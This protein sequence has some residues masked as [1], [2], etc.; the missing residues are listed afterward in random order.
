MRGDTGADAPTSK[1]AG[2]SFAGGPPAYSLPSALVRLMLRNPILPILIVALPSFAL[3]VPFY[4]TL[5]NFANLLLASS[6]LLLLASGGALVMIT[7]NIDLSVEGTLA[8]TSMIAAWLM[9]PAEA[10]GS[11]LLMAPWL[12]ILVSIG[13]GLAIGALNALLVEGLGVNPFIVT[14]GM[15]L[16]LKGAAAIPTQATT[17]YG[18][19]EQY[20]WVGLHDLGGVSWVVIISFLICLVL[21]IWLR[22]SVSGRH[23]YALGGS[24][25]AAY[26]NGVLPRRTTMLAYCIAGGLAAIAGWLN[27]ARLNSA[28]ASAGDGITFTVFAAMIIGGI[29]LSGGRGGLWGVLGGVILLTSIDNVL[30][31]VALNPLYVNFVRGMVILLAVVLIV[32]RQKLAER[33]RIQEPAA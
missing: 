19:P 32:I 31:L 22:N 23:L 25:A 21:S 26:E 9:V 4:A 28:S 3:F 18:L 24:K 6:I 8:F 10:G 14:I 13:I 12:A 11:G 1:Q 2:S 33:L 16:A 17:V 30:N 15:L 27:A 20:S 5:G 7:G 29:A